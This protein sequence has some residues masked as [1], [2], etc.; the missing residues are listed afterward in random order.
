MTRAPRRPDA[1]V[2]NWRGA[3]ARFGQDGRSEFVMG[4]NRLVLGTAVL[5]ASWASSGT[6]GEPAFGQWPLAIE[7]W[8]L[9]AAV[10]QADLIW[11]RRPSAARRTLAVLLDTGGASIVMAMGNASG[12]WVAPTVYLWIVIG[13]GLR[14]G[15]SA[16][17]VS[18][19]F[20]IAGFTTA[21]ASTPYWYEQGALT[22]GIGVGLVVLPSYIYVLTRRLAEAKQAAEAATRAKDLFL[23]SVSHELRTPL[24]SITG[25]TKLLGEATSTPD[26]DQLVRTLDASSKALLGHVEAL[27][28]FA[29][30][31]TGH[32]N[33]S[34]SPFAL[35]DLVQQSVSVIEVTARSK[36][37]GL[38]ASV[39]DSA[40][41]ALV[42]D[43]A[44]LRD[45]LLNLL[46]NAVK[47]T[48][49]GTVSLRVTSTVLE[50][51][52]HRLRFEVADTG[53]GITAEAQSRIFDRFTQ[54]DEAVVR[55]FGGTG[56][57][58]ALC[59]RLVRA[60]GGRIGVRSEP[61]QGS[62]FWFEVEL[63]D[64][65]EQSNAEPPRPMLPPERQTRV[66]LADDT[67]ANRLVVRMY[68]ERLGFAVIAVTNGEAALDALVAGEADVGLLDLNMP[69]LDG[70][71]VMQQYRCVM[72]SARRVP[73]LGITA[74]GAGTARRRCLDAGM[75]DCLLKPVFQ[76]GLGEAIERAL[77]SRVMT[78][79]A[80]GQ[81]IGNGRVLDETVLDRLLSATGEALF[82]A[83]VESLAADASSL[84]ERI[85]AAAER[86]D[87]DAFRLDSHSLRSIALNL[88]APR[89]QAACDGWD[90][91]SATM[92]HQVGLD[93]L[94]GLKRAW[95]ETSFA[96]H[97]HIASRM[98]TRATAL[99]R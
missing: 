63:A 11:R 42:G 1:L 70:A 5:I 46:G 80:K 44:R 71:M 23:A 15:A 27:L 76:S 19:A 78:T 94:A 96:L 26:R 99:G 24:Q 53:P 81:G 25:A 38:S 37:I 68:L 17:V 2:E 69:D 41:A 33:L 91:V 62:T 61:G 13:N 21:A 60:M 56:L 4:C 55:R 36:G 97:K 49:S 93:G 89:L 82:P 86:D 31:E 45:V 67:P 74:D 35:S 12:A 88:G 50:G 92:V 7:A 79:D 87:A 14:F 20:S 85:E 6:N 75:E 40:P 57:G 73:V 51:S 54:A 84:V 8:W 48:M 59:D 95:A 66:L 32:F 28:D 98:N 22:A 34:P 72:P 47:F 39:G 64:A 83:A 65:A 77:T 30:L 29:R 43:E 58:L 10:L 3:W 52:R 90:Q 16:I 18:T 9:A